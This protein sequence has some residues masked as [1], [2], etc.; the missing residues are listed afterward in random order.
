MTAAVKKRRPRGQDMLSREVSIGCLRCTR[1][2]LSSVPVLSRVCPR[3]QLA[4][5][6]RPERCKFSVTT[7]F[8]GKQ[9]YIVKRCLEVGGSSFWQHWYEAADIE[10]A[11]MAIPDGA[12]RF[13]KSLSDPSDVVETWIG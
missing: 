6:V 9:V 8:E 11:R 13:G 5:S 1:P 12:R 10:D 3:C 2:F 4:R 7:A